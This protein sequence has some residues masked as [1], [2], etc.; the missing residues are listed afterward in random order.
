MKK[1]A[2][3]VSENFPEKKSMMRLYLIKFTELEK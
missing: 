1:S 3:K 2:Y